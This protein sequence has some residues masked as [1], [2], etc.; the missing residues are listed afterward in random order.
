[1]SEAEGS[2]IPGSA[3]GMAGWAASPGRTLSK[4]SPHCHRAAVARAAVDRDARV[5]QVATT[6]FVEDPACDHAGRQVLPKLI[7]AAASPP[8]SR[9]PPAQPWLRRGLLR[10]HRGCLLRVDR[11]RGFQRRPGVTQTATSSLSR[12][13]RAL[14][15]SVVT[16]CTLD[17]SA[18]PRGEGCMKIEV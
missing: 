7:A 12:N 1:M 8:E 6:R 10:A 16:S 17:P 5:L 11:V 3:F 14:P 15:S 13:A 4:T 9:T 18:E 2:S